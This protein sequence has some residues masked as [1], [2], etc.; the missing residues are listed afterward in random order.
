MA[1]CE[2]TFVLASLAFAMWVV[3][4]VALEMTPPVSTSTV[5]T[6]ATLCRR[7]CGQGQKK[8]NTVERRIANAQNVECAE[9][10]MSTR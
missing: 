5:F 4:E 7:R 1:L 8:W 9:G 3:V 6:V 2:A 10:G